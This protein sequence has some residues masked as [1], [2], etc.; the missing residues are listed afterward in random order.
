MDS[1]ASSDNDSS[2]D[3]EKFTFQSD[4]TKLEFYQSDDSEKGSKISGVS[5]FGASRVSVL[6]PGGKDEN[7]YEIKENNSETSDYESPRDK[8]KKSSR[9]IKHDVQAV[10]GLFESLILRGKDV[11]TFYTDKKTLA[12]RENEPERA[13]LLYRIVEELKLLSSTFLEHDSEDQKSEYSSFRI[14]NSQKEISTS[15]TLI[16]EVSK[17]SHYVSVKLRVQEQLKEL[18]ILLRKG[19][20]YLRQTDPN[21]ITQTLFMFACDTARKAAIHQEMGKSNEA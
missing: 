6:K 20:F 8:S 21:T 9:I 18:L 10:M 13:V 7:L 4:S 11:Q 19:F 12:L 5:S 1:R 3:D 2:A 16:S 17:A 15:M 14:F